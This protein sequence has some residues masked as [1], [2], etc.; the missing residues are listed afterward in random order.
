MAKLTFVSR[1]GR[2]VEL[3]SG[4]RTHRQ[5]KSLKPASHLHLV[6][7]SK[8]Q[9]LQRPRP[10]SKASRAGGVHGNQLVQ[11][12][13]AKETPQ[14]C[15]HWLLGSSKSGSRLLSKSSRASR[16]PKLSTRND[17]LFWDAPAMCSRAKRGPWWGLS[18]RVLR[19]V[20]KV[21][22]SACISFRGFGHQREL[23]VPWK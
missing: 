23:C 9:G 18:S 6:R 8:S 17:R 7:C 12:P 19:H 14:F 16:I 4:R 15:R 20:A 1:P 13:Q 11:S 2:E 3:N 10:P 5:A 21:S 22:L